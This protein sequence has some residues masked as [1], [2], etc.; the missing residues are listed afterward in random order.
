MTGIETNGAGVAASIPLL[1]GENLLE[2]EWAPNEHLQKFH[3]K[4]SNGGKQIYGPPLVIDGESDDRLNHEVTA[5]AVDKTER[6]FPACQLQYV[7][8]PGVS[9]VP[10][11]QASQRL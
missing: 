6:L 11:L 4:R 9:H 5:Q 7:S 1:L 3:E 10:A 2:P 8:V